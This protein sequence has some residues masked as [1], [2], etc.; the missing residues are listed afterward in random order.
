MPKKPQRD[1]RGKPPMRSRAGVK[2]NA[3]PRLHSVK[4]LLG[5]QF[6]SLRRLT[7]E[8]AR[9]DFWSA[10]LSQQL[11]PELRERITGVHEREGVLVVFAESA[12]W[13]ARLRFALLELQAALPDALPAVTAIDVRVLPRG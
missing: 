8:A 2:S 5:R 9:Q 13:S 12:A 10:W 7:D 1:K 4:D 6:P 11:T 3:R